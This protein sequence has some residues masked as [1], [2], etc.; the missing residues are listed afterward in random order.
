L[1]YGLLSEEGVSVLWHA[2]RNPAFTHVNVNLISHRINPAAGRMSFNDVLQLLGDCF[3]VTLN[4][5][6]EV[7][8]LRQEL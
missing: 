1:T 6:R 5:L 3:T 2:S 8:S 7:F 4:Q